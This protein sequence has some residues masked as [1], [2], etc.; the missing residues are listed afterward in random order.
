MLERTIESIVERTNYPY[1]IFV[2]DSNSTDGTM[3]YLKNV[4]V[5]GKI[6]DHLFLPE[7]Q[8]QSVA[9]NKAFAWMQEWEKRRPSDELFITTNDDIIPPLLGP[10]CWLEQ[11]LDLFYRHE[12]NYTLGGIAM[13]IERTARTEIDESKDLIRLYKGFPSVFRM[14]KRSDFAQ[15]GEF[16]FRKLKHFDSNSMGTTM[17]TC[18]KKRFYFTTHIYGSHIGFAVE[19]KGYEEGVDYLTNPG[20]EKLQV[21]KQKPYADIDLKTNVP[22]KIRHGCDAYEQKLRDDRKAELDGTLEKPEVTVIVLTCRRY[23]GLKKILNSV[24]NTTEDIKYKLLVIID[25]DDTTAYNYCI[26]N[27][28]DCIL[29]NHHRDFVAQANLGVYACDTPFFTILGDD[30]EITE[31]G[32]LSRGLALFKEKFPDRVGILSFND[33]IQNGKV[34][35]VGISSKKFVHE[36]G[37]NFHYPGYRHY[38]SDRELAN[39]AKEMGCFYHEKSINLIH[40]HPGK[41]GEKDETYQLSENEFWQHD[42]NLKRY[43][44]KHTNL[45][46]E[47]NN[48]L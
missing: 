35:I 11:M 4:K 44:Q 2:V 16:P 41:S 33:Q 28:I 8:G 47:R 18:L 32:W 30:L 24:K 34:F 13:R 9:L 17:E 5:L 39:L 43:R 19:N 23:D 15:L 3:G 20:P 36:I 37:G 12:E 10:K 40:N 42:Q 14:L 31:K 27:N 25:R 22:I 1:K 48:Y 7:N 38:G 6:F 21:Y 45:L 29:S 46:K 26:E